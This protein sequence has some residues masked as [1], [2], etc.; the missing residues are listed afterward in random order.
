[1]NAVTS[2]PVCEAE[3]LATGRWDLTVTVADQLSWRELWAFAAQVAD[4]Y[5]SGPMDLLVT[6]PVA[7]RERTGD[8]A[9]PEIILVDRVIDGSAAPA[10]VPVNESELLAALT[11]SLLDALDYCGTRQFALSHE[12]VLRRTRE[13]LSRPEVGRCQ[14][15]S[16]PD[17]QFAVWIPESDPW[18]HGADLIELLDICGP[19]RGGQSTLLGQMV[20]AAGPRTVRGNVAVS[21]DQPDGWRVLDRLRA[22]GWRVVGAR[23]RFRCDDS[24][25]TV[26]D[27]GPRWPDWAG[28]T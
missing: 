5:A 22:T 16:G 12:D 3:D 8:L 10:G 20:G 4:D 9:A 17:A 18:C 6:T 13:F 25:I 28:T 19:G 1:L 24:G 26:P 27:R 15:G 23:W 11:E 14:V 21:P 2:S 7:G